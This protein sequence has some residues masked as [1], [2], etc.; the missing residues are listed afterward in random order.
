MRNSMRDNTTRLSVAIILLGVGTIIT[1][2]KLMIDT[3]MIQSLEQAVNQLEV[4]KADGLVDCH[5]ERD[6]LDYNVYGREK[7]Q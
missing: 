5:I 2:I 3:H 1:S 4:C 7:Q 6:G